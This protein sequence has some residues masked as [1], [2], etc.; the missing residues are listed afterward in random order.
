M[1]RSLWGTPPPWGVSKG[2]GQSSTPPPPEILKSR[3]KLF[4]GALGSLLDNF[5]RIL[6]QLTLLFFCLAGLWEPSW[7]RFLEILT[8][9]LLVRAFRGAFEDLPGSPPDS[10]SWFRHGGSSFF[11]F[12]ADSTSD[13]FWAPLGVLLGLGPL[14]HEISLGDRLGGSRTSLG[15]LFFASKTL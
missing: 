11:Q 14:L 3:L 13:P 4:S 1:L 12:S 8:S 15:V 5:F 10:K 6:D 7:A 9:K 2:G